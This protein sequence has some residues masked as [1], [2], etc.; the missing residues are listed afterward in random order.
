MRFVVQLIGILL[1]VGFVLKYWWVIALVLAAVAVWKFGPGVWARHE[2]AVAAER[3]R[4]AAIAAR[5]DEQH[6]LVTQGDERGV[7]GDYPPAAV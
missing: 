3:H 6:R 5:A 1:L 7:Y 4:L 2:A